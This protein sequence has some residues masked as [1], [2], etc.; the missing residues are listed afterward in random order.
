M[1]LF[2]RKCI[3]ARE[4][5]S[6]FFF[7]LTQVFLSILLLGQFSSVADLHPFLWADFDHFMLSLPSSL[8]PVISLS[9]AYIC[10][11]CFSAFKR[12]SVFWK[13]PPCPA[14]RCSLHSHPTNLCPVDS[15]LTSAFTPGDFMC[16]TRSEAI[17]CVKWMTENKKSMFLHKN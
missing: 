14:W 11:N 2:H 15:P 5:A 13:S 6:K 1:A 8:V 4:I 16:K 3:H 7:G 12:V 10:P 9:Q 17:R